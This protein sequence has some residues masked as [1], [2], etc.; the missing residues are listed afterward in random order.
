MVILL[1]DSREGK[2]WVGD[3]KILAKIIAVVLVISIVALVV[4]YFVL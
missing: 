4:L 2:K 3:N 1:I